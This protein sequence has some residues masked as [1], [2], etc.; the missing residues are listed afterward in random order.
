MRARDG[1]LLV[2]HGTVEDLDDLGEVLARIR[3][4]RPAPPGFVA[5]LRSRYE[6]IGGSPLLDVTKAQAARL[7]ERLEVPVLVGMRL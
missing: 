3:G 7:A 4:G 1:V 5:E 2:A 6:A